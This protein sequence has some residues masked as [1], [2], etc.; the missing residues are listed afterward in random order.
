LPP[1]GGDLIDPTI[2]IEIFWLVSKVSVRRP[3]C[4]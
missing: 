1:T 4:E 3:L 2:A